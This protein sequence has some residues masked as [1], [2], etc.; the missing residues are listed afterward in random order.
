MNGVL[1]RAWS[2]NGAAGGNDTVTTG[3]GRDVVVGL[4]D[5]GYRWRAHRSLSGM[6]VLKEYDFVSGDGDT[7]SIGIGQFINLVRRNVAMVYVVENNGVYGLT[8]GQFSATADIGFIERRL[9]RRGGVVS[10]ATA[11]ADAASASRL[12]SMVMVVRF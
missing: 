11:A 2:T 7:A 8:K 9:L 12:P 10:S 1:T 5:S 3:L 4:L 6:R